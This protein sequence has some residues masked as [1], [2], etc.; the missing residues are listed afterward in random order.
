MKYSIRLLGIMV[1]LVI[2]LPLPWKARVLVA[3]MLH[4]MMSFLLAHIPQI[5]ESVI[6]ENRR[7]RMG[8]Q[9][10]GEMQSIMALEMV[11]RELE[12]RNFQ[13]EALRYTIMEAEKNNIGN[14]NLAEYI[15][16]NTLGSHETKKIL[17]LVI[18]L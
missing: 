5:Y 16:D 1:A 6:A 2:S 4:V 14:D 17:Q 3:K 15:C 12:A 9:N 18:A 7:H 11:L 10:S 8:K 13:P